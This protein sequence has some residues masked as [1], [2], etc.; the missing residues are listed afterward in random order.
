MAIARPIDRRLY[1]IFDRAHSLITKEAQNYLQ[2]TS[3][4]GTSQAAVLIYLGYHD[5][6]RLTDL[7]KA[8]G[9][10]NASITGLVERME[11]KLLLARMTLFSDRRSKA[12][13]LTEKG[14]SEREKVMNNFRNFNDRM[15]KGLSEEEISVVM[16]F[17]QTAPENV[18]FLSEK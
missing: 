10:N 6:C 12:V 1:F 11:A 14:W 2:K 17:L 15:M 3:E 13:A 4:I 18:R 7:A 9:R 5:R 8:I 16:K